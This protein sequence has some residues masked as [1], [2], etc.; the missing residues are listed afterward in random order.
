MDWNQG[1]GNRFD[2]VVI[3]AGAS[4]L[5]F[6]Y[7]ALHGTEQ[8]FN[9]E[10]TL[11]IGESGLWA[12]TVETRPSHLVGQPAPLLSTLPGHFPAAAG[13]HAR[14]LT[15]PTDVDK[16]PGEAYGTHYLR[17]DA[18]VR[19]NAALRDTVVK[20]R[21]DARLGLWFLTDRVSQVTRFGKKYRVTSAGNGIFYAAQVIVATG[22]G[23]PQRLEELKVS[24]RLAI[25]IENFGRC[26]GDPRGYPEIVDAVT[27]YTTDHPEGL[28]V[29]I[30]GGSATSA[31]SAAHAIRSKASFTWMCRR[32]ID[33][34]STEGNPVGRNTPAIVEA[35]KRKAIRQ[36][37]ITK[38]EVLRYDGVDEGP[39][40][41]V[42][43]DEQ[44]LA[45]SA[46]RYMRDRDGNLVRDPRGMTSK[47]GQV[48]YFHQIVY[49]VGSDPLGEGSIGQFLD[50]EIRN[51]L[52]C[53]W[54]RDFKSTR[55]NGPGDTKESV[56]ALC[57]PDQSLWVVGAAVF[58]SGKINGSLRNLTLTYA[59]QGDMLP[60]AGRPPE[61]VPI[62]TY[63]MKKLT[64]DLPL[65]EKEGWNLDKA[66]PSQINAKLRTL[67]KEP[68]NAKAV[69]DSVLWDMTTQILET[70]A[71]R[72]ET[73]SESEL[74]SIVA[75]YME[76]YGGLERAD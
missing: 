73:L 51:S 71:D 3:G 39:R 59:K 70:R 48:G 50:Q 44:V 69:F 67:F 65:T 19:H 68:V 41:K 4:A 42:T 36:G 45:T 31:W 58:G 62:L 49:A 2:Q 27:Y 64:G 26:K 23:P 66:T 30:Y 74:N 24:G 6:L 43:F 21:G 17:T 9:S 52:E 35:T 46:P 76:V 16:K 60:H 11:V 55:Y 38:I 33:Q 29:L 28:E 22:V 57:T 25:R 14:Q 1:V 15:N 18:F 72:R 54:D 61:G 5:N 56:I 32:G 8:R 37:E 63:A 75:A 47:V 53:Y 7:H 10:S 12:R 20:E 40:L 34:I 13:E